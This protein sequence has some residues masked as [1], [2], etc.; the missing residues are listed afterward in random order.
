MDDV[1]GKKGMVRILRFMLKEMLTNYHARPHFIAY[2]FTDKSL[3]LSLAR[4]TR[5]IPLAGWTPKGRSEVKDAC[6]RFDAVIFEKGGDSLEE[7][8]DEDNL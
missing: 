3:S 1:K 5:R 4:F 7:I 8:F 2:R 6:Q